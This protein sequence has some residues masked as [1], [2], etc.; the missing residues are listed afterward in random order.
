MN[1]QSF[2]IWSF[3]CYW[4]L[5]RRTVPPLLDFNNVRWL[6]PTLVNLQFTY[7]RTVLLLDHHYKTEQ[8]FYLKIWCKLCISN[9][10]MLTPHPCISIQIF[11]AMCYKHRRKLVNIKCSGWKNQASNYHI[12]IAQWL[13]MW[14]VEIVVLRCRSDWVII[15]TY[16]L[17]TY[18]IVKYKN[19]QENANQ[20]TI[21]AHLWN[22]D[23]SSL[24]LK[25]RH[26]EL[27][28]TDAQC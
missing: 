6:Y 8:L 2:V 17:N 26:N 20:Q 1:W 23:L 13:V 9:L 22:Y 5:I 3:L 15:C 24:L 14:L 19:L 11:N 7:H 4:V 16:F 18:Y 25:T 28:P 21:T 10:Y 27:C 12:L